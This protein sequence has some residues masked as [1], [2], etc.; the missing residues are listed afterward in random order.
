MIT[1][2]FTRNQMKHSNTLLLKTFPSSCCPPVGQFGHVICGAGNKGAPLQEGRAYGKWE[3]LY[4]RE[5]HREYLRPLCCNADPFFFCGRSSNVEWTYKRSKAPPKWCPFSI[6]PPSQDCSFPLGLGQERFWV[7]ILKGRYINLIDWLNMVVS[8][9]DGGAGREHKVV[10]I[11]SVHF[12][13]RHHMKE[14]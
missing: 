8:L 14:H 1:L 5:E 9:E 13:F 4:R 12:D 10:S 3:R 6:P 7:G 2:W 11:I